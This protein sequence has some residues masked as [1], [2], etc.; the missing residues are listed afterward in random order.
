MQAT[1][2]DCKAEIMDRK[3]ITNHEIGWLRVADG[4]VAPVGIYYVRISGEKPCLN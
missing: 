3:G 2:L 1:E 4:I